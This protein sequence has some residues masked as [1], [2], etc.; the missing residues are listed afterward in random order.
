[1]T[2]IWT[3]GNINAPVWVLLLA[4][5]FVPFR[6]L[7]P[8]QEVCGHPW[9]FAVTWSYAGNRDMAPRGVTLMST[10]TRLDQIIYDSTFEIF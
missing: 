9:S 6:F 5:L 3:F 2:E 7:A 10:K 8:D 4:L 1:M